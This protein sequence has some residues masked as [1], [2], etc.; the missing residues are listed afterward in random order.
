MTRSDVSAVVLFV[1][2]GGAVGLGVMGYRIITDRES[3][4]HYSDSVAWVEVH[5]TILLALALFAAACLCTAAVLW[6]R[7]GRGK[8]P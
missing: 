5:T 2:A 8:T 1:A 6:A 3:V 4:L 7:G